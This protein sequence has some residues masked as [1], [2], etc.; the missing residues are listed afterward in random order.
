MTRWNVDSTNKRSYFNINH[1]SQDA[2]FFNKTMADK[3]LKH[4]RYNNINIYLG[5][6]GCDNYLLYLANN[7]FGSPKNL[8]LYIISHHLHN[9]KI[10]NKEN[11]RG[12][13]YSGFDNKLYS[14]PSAFEI[15]LFC[16]KGR[17]N[18][19]QRIYLYLMVK[20]R[21]LNHE[22]HEYRKAKITVT[23]RLLKLTFKSLVMIMRLGN[24]QTFLN[25]H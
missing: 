14:I 4:L 24:V 6:P 7:I 13:S 17:L 20:I 2:W 8:G 16:K 10:R 22:I 11:V 18:M 1:Q 3:L 12:F 25:L 21:Y 15:D 19:I 23:K 5:T 9:S